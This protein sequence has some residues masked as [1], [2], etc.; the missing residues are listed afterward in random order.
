LASLVDIAGSKAGIAAEL[1]VRR[2]LRDAISAP[3]VVA[4]KGIAVPVN[5][6]IEPDHIIVAT[7]FVDG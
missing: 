2:S 5:I 1:A 6:A 3:E 7:I 4:R